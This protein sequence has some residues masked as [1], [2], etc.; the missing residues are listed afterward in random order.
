MANPATEKPNASENTEHSLFQVPLE[1]HS[2]KHMNLGVRSRDLPKHDQALA[3]S[4]M[5]ALYITTLF[6]S[7][8]QNNL[9]EATSRSHL[10][11]SP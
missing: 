1:L 3:F 10:V 2:Q 4:E 11:P 7:E 6:L 5:L 8:T 9:L